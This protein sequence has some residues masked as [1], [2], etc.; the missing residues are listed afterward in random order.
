M[1]QVNTEIA[2]YEFKFGLDV[3]SLRQNDLRSLFVR[4]CKWC[5]AT[6]QQHE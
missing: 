4:L 2:M 3:L 1:T 6:A 5:E